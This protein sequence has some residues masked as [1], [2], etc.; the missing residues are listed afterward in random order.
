M[1]MDVFPHVKKH[2]VLAAFVCLAPMHS[3]ETSHLRRIL[4]GITYTTGHSR[5]LRAFFY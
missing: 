3:F 2:V 4:G 5:L 1:C